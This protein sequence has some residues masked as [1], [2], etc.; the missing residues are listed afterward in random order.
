MIA[1]A[2]LLCSCGRFSSVIKLS[3]TPHINFSFFFLST[4]GLFS[5]SHPAVQQ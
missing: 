1:F 2:S 5:F 3:I 4:F